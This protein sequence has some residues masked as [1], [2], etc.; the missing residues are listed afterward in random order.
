MWVMGNAYYKG[1]GIIQDHEKALV[2]WRKAAEQGQFVISRGLPEQFKSDL[3][4]PAGNSKL[5]LKA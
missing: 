3:V 4:E 5:R 1:E 2:W